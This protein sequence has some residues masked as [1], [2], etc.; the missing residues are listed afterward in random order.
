MDDA[1][2]RRGRPCPH[3]THGEASATLGALALITRAYG[4][5]WEVLGT[6]DG[7]RR[8][9][10]GALVGECLGAEGILDGQ[11]RD[12]RFERPRPSQRPR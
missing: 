9:R 8:A 7:E 6:L 3:R 12:L 10:A 5:L 11:A 2:E 4:L 1:R